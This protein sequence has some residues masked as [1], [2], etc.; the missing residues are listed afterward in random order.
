M[1]NPVPPPVK[2]LAPPK[3]V[4]YSSSHVPAPKSPHTV[5]PHYPTRQVAGAVLDPLTKDAATT[6]H[7]GSVNMAQHLGMEDQAATT[8]R[9]ADALMSRLSARK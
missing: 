2:P 1:K 3:Q 5:I 6:R 9:I 4:H 8:K 7:L